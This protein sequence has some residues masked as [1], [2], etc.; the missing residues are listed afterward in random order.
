VAGAVILGVNNGR[1]NPV[2]YSEWLRKGVGQFEGG[3]LV[4]LFCIKLLQ[5]VNTIP[6]LGGQEHQKF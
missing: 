4:S 2:S 5:K 3:E 6:I 1:S